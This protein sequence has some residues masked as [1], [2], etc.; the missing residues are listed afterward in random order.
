MYRLVDGAEGKFTIHRS[1]GEIYL[2]E[3]LTAVQ[4]NTQF[5]L[6][7]EAVDRG[8]T[9]IQSTRCGIQLHLVTG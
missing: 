4:E 9:S 2:S 8:K 3:L 6:L 1:T 5:D 7:V